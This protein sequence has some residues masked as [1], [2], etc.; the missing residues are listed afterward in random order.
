VAAEGLAHL[1]DLLRAQAQ[2]AVLSSGVIHVENPLGMPLAARALGTAAAVKGS[3]LQQGAA[4]EVAGTRE[5]GGKSVAFPV[6][7]ITCHLYRRYIADKNLST[8]F[9]RKCLCKCSWHY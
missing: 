2:L 3:A 4:Q 1:R 9:Y 5:C 8:Y 6:D 7:A